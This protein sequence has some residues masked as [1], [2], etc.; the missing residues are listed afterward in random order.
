MAVIVDT[1]RCANTLAW[2]F[3]ASITH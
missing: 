3:V 1:I 2:I